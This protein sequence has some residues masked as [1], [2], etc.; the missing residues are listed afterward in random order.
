MQASV[1]SAI[2]LA[3]DVVV[4]HKTSQQKAM[5]CEVSGCYHEGRGR[6]ALMS[7]PV[8]CRG[9]GSSCRNGS[10]MWW[11]EHR[12]QQRQLIRLAV[13]LAAA[14]LTAGCFEPLYGTHATLGGVPDSVHT[15]LAAVDI[16][17][18]KAPLGSPVERI[19]VG[20]RNALQF[21]LHGGGEP[22]ARPIASWSMS[23]RPN[24]RW[25][26]TRSAGGRMR[27]SIRSSPTTNLIE[28]ATGKIVVT[29]TTV[30]HVDYDI[31]GREQR[32]AKQRAQR[33]AEDQA[34]KVVAEAIRNRLASYFV[35]GT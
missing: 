21:D 5:Y 2:Q 25:S 14:S 34:T 9:G 8:I 23:A 35:A 29:D 10:S 7:E 28:I 6:A 4:G 15:R 18:I 31:P 26:S 22:S 32:F 17:T 27:R 12:L 20:M 1:R 16:P 24:G 3:A 13:V 11:L 30:A 33:N 19:A